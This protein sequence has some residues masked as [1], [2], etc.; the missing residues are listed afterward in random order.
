MTTGV[1][2]SIP[3]DGRYQMADRDGN[4]PHLSSAI[5]HPPRSDAPGLPVLTYHAIDDSGSVTSTSPGVFARTID[6]LVS[7]GFVGVDLPGWVAKGR[8]SV[9]GGFAVAF[10]D[11]LR[12]I[13][14]AVE[15]LRQTKIPATVF[16]VSRHVGRANDWPG[17]PRGVPRA[18][19]L[20]W[21]ELADL[22]RRGVTF[23]AHGATHARLDGLRPGDVSAELCASRD[24]I[25]S[26]LNRPCRLF[27]YPYGRSSR[28]VR[29][30]A[31]RHFDAAFGTRLDLAHGGQDRLALPRLDAYYLRSPR[32][33]DRLITG[34]L[35]PWMAVRR[36][37]RAV[38]RALDPV[39]P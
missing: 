22:A 4:L 20:D 35:G 2:K 29:D 1:S 32:V 39:R 12:S 36:T 17:Q 33:V 30:R 14:G 23:G 15:I 34:R 31:S 19:L 26:R 37:L 25:E 13:L 7:A 11:G 3:T 10:D 38:R 27:A 8:P 6:R 5:G 28:A 9:P 18:D 24:A 21:S 16:L